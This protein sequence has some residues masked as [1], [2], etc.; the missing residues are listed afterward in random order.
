MVQIAGISYLDEFDHFVKET[1]REKMYLHYMDDTRTIEAPDADCAAI[2]SKMAVKLAEVGLAFHPRKTR[3]VT[4]DKGGLF[5]GFVFRVTPS[6]KV[7]MLRDPDKV[8]DN[9]RHLRRLAGL[10]RRGRRTVEDFEKCYGCIRACMTE[11]N[12]VRLIRNMDNFV[13]E[14]RREINESQQLPARAA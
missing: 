13:N 7:L 9:R 12:S 1:L 10:V 4:A 6:G 11:G 8:K 14:L 5:L 2:L 3:V